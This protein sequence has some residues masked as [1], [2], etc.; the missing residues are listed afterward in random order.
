MADISLNESHDFWKN[1]PDASVYRVI[2]LLESVEKSFYDGD[3]EYE[4]V[5]EKLGDSIDLMDANKH[6]DPHKIL[7]VLA[8]T[9]TSRYLKFLQGMDSVSPGAASK[10]IQAAEK[11]TP[12]NKSGRLFLKRNIYFERYR[13]L[14]R[15]LAKDRLDL[16]T[17]ALE[18]S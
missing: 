2:V 4:E 7:Q 15:I 6:P 13:L 9:K 18:V 11:S 5:M 10:V 12:D 14:F 8:Y 3:S 17:E 16:V 1:F